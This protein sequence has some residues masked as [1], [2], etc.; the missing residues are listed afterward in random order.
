LESRIEPVFR[1]GIR[2]KSGPQPTAAPLPE[3]TLTPADAHC[4]SGPP[5]LTQKTTLRR[6][7]L[8][9]NTQPP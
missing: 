3:Q 1:P 8:Y 5:H 2:L 4:S 9:V 6:Y 7:G